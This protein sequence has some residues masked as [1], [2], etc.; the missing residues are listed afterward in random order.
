M[1][2]FQQSQTEI[3]TKAFL[4]Y[5]YMTSSETKILSQQTGLPIMCIRN[6]FVRARVRYNVKEMSLATLHTVFAGEYS[7]YI[8]QIQ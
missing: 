2:K 1:T 7:T 5:P 6:W 4:W 3:L 8:E